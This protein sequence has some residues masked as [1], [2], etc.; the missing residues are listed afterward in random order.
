MHRLYKPH[1]GAG[2]RDS[3]VFISHPFM[4]PLCSVTPEISEGV[5]A[6]NVQRM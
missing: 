6:G 1:N 5:R 3:T 2:L 4:Q